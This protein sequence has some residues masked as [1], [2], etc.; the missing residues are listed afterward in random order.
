MDYDPWASEFG[1]EGSPINGPIKELQRHGSIIMQFTGL[2]DK[3]EVDIYESDLVR[4]KK[5]DKEWIGETK[6]S[7]TQGVLVGIEPIWIIDCE[8]IGNI[9]EDPR[10]AKTGGTRESSATDT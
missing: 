7:P 6:I 8:V 1:G 10:E 5:L 3:N 9:W 2:K 4:C